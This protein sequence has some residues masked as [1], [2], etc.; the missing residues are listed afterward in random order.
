VISKFFIERPVFASVLS[1]IIVLAGLVAMRALPISQYPQIVPPEVMITA[2]YPGATAQTISQS[3]AAPLEQQINGV[4]NML[5]M[6]STSTDSG[7]LRL[8]VTFQIGTDPDQATINVNNR[9]QRAT[10]LLPEEVRR[11]Y[12][13]SSLQFVMHGAAPCPVHVKHAMIEWW[14]PVIHDHYGGTET[15]AV[16][17][18]DSHEW[19][20]HPGS[21]G[22]ALANA[23]LLVLNE[24]GEEVERDGV[25]EI[26]CR[27]MYYADFTYH[28]D[29]AK[30]RRAEKRGLIALGDMGYIDRDGYLYLCGRAT[31]MIISGGV[32]IYPREAEDVLVVHPSIEDVAVIGT[33]DAEMGERVT[34]FVQLRAGVAPTPMLAE[35]LIAHTREH[36]SSF[37]C[38]REVRFVD[39]LPRLPNGKLLKRMLKIG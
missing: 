19:L 4:E 8:I 22:R 18:L 3:V 26:V 10:A 30:R 39:D 36:L 9:A 34:A 29:D 12:D 13:L 1:I 38:P 11:E 28:G 24:A 32:N 27:H 37:K 20:A 16:T 2:T 6:R 15:G 7:T 31:D 21:V 14:G 25:G 17:Y 5:Y 35:E 33:P 23:Q